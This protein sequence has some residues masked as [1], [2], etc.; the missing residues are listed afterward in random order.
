LKD[1]KFN[2]W[3]H[4]DEIAITMYILLFNL[5]IFVEKGVLPIWKLMNNGQNTKCPNDTK[6]AIK[7]IDEH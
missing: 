7:S 6:E 3:R 2:P 1:K 4:I 5:Q